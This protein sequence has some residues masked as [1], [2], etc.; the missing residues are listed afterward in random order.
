MKDL[1]ERI[2][3]EPFLLVLIQNHDGTFHYKR[4][5][6]NF[7]YESSTAYPKRRNV[8][9]SLVIVPVYPN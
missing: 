2:S 7:V 4:C 9:L 6:S 3:Y 8:S 5:L 1:H